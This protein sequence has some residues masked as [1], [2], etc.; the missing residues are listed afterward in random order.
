M[1]FLKGGYM[2]NWNDTQEAYYGIQPDF[3]ERPEKSELA[4]S[5]L[6]IEPPHTTRGA[7]AHIIAPFP[8]IGEGRGLGEG[9]GM[10]HAQN[11]YPYNPSNFVPSQ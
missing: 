9:L 1:S 10:V 6:G 11:P 4:H 5:K 2:G 7:H 8:G 3:S